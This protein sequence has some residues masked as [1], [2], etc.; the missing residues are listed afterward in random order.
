M[1]KPK[2]P[3]IP[4]FGSAYALTRFL[5]RLAIISLFALLGHHG[6]GKTLASML[7]LAAIYCILI[8]ALRREHPFGPLPTHFDEAAAYGV[9]GGL[10][11]WAS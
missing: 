11:A 10:A 2:T 7:T 5:L 9:I 6:F 3:Q 1:R 8:A 4:H